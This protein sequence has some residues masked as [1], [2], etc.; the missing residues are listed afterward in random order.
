MINEFMIA[1]ILPFVS[2]FTEFTDEKDRPLFGF[3]Y[4]G[5]LSVMIALNFAFVIY[6]G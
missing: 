4:I 6:F 3:Y 2:L 5:M 1:M